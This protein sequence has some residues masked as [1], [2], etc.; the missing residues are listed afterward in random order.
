MASVTMIQD[1]EG[2]KKNIGAHP[3]PDGGR[4]FLPGDQVL[5]GVIPAMHASRMRHLGCLT[6][7]ELTDGFENTLTVV[8]LK[9]LFPDVRPDGNCHFSAIITGDGGFT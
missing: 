3:F 5:A 8:T 6:G 7:Q 4:I 1:V 2:K 9:R